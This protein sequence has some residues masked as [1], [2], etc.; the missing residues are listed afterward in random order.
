VFTGP[1]I[2]WS[3]AVPSADRIQ[4]GGL[5]L[6]PMHAGGPAQ[7]PITPDSLLLNTQHDKQI[8]YRAKTKGKCT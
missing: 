6:V 3:G 8:V 4:T 2:G 1:G 7:F 5:A